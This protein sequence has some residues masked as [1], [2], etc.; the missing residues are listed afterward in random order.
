ML[1]MEREVNDLLIVAH[2]SVLRVLCAY[3]VE[4]SA[5]VFCVSRKGLTLGNSIYVVS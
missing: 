4:T 3:F 5:D 1:E 2:E